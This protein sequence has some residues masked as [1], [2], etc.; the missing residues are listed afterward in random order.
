MEAVFSACVA[1]QIWEF[2]QAAVVKGFGSCMPAAQATYSQ[3]LCML[4]GTPYF[5]C[6]V[7]FDPHPH[8]R[9]AFRHQDLEGSSSCL[10]YIYGRA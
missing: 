8:K 1:L 3:V 4:P 10:L 2:R 6:P 9:L 7:A 5:V